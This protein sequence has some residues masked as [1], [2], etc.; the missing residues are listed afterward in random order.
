MKIAFFTETYLPNIDGVF[1]SL[2]S[3]KSEFEK[4]GHKL[5]I[6]TAGDRR[7]S[8]KQKDT[9]VYYFKSLPTI[10]FI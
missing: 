4:K 8:E 10:S 9:T 7:R 5:V 2:L 3:A 1:T 6:L